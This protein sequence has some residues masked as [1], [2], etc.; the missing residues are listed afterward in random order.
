[1]C[2]GGGCGDSISVSAIVT[3]ITVRMTAASDIVITILR[4]VRVVYF[5]QQMGASHAVPWSKSSFLV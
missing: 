2:F 5:D 1:M 3:V 4:E